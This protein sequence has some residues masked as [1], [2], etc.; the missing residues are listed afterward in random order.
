MNTVLVVGGGFSGLVMA[1]ALGYAGVPT[2]CIDSGGEG[3]ESDIRTTALALSSQRILSG[4]GLWGYLEGEAEPIKEIRVA[5]N[6]RRFF[7]HYDHRDV[8]T[9]PLGWIIDNRSFYRGLQAYV[10]TCKSVTYLT[11]ECV[12]SIERES[13]YVVVTLGSGTSLRGQIVIGADGRYSFVRRSADIRTTTYGYGQK[14]IVCTIQHEREHYGI[15]IEHFLPEGPFAVLPMTGRRSSVIWCEG[16]DI[17]EGYLRLDGDDLVRQLSKRLGGYLG[18]VR[19]LGDLVCYPL[20][21]QL[22]HTQGVHRLALVGDAAHL[23][24]PVA[25]QGLN[26]AIRDIGVLAELIVDAYRLGLDIG[27]TEVITTYRRRRYFDNFAF[28]RTC[29][30]LVR[31]FSNRHTLL[32]VFLDGGFYMVDRL[33]WL[34]KF[35]MRYAMGLVGDVPR[36]VQGKRL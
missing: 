7:I 32:H 31:V 8:G 9:D 13:W 1:A 17:A 19:L 29:D 33:P 21:L 35:F 27:S 12:T 34:K 36:L 18:E 3:R 14:A 20:L 10:R 30:S 15:A 28:S 2:V 26:M 25:G 24:H 5:D 22:A 4:I 16:E 23:I 11:G 6:Y